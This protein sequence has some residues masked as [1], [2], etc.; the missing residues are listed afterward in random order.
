MIISEKLSRCA[1]VWRNLYDRLKQ[2]LNEHLMNNNLYSHT[3][4]RKK[5]PSSPVAVQYVVCFSECSFAKKVNEKFDIHIL[6]FGCHCRCC[7]CSLYNFKCKIHVCITYTKRISCYW[8]TFHQVQFFDP[9]SLFS[10]PTFLL[11]K[12][13]FNHFTLIT[14]KTR[15]ENLHEISEW[16]LR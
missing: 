4:T 12:E 9:F 14:A 6:C 1:I 2:I 11:P 7:C 13:L 5:F 15:R 8:K 10:S 16:L 3:R